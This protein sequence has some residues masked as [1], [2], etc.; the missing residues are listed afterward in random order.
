MLDTARRL[1]AV[2]KDL[3]KSIQPGPSIFLEFQPFVGISLPPRANP[4]EVKEIPRSL[5]QFLQRCYRIVQFVDTF[6]VILEPVRR[7][8]LVVSDQQPAVTSLKRKR[9]VKAMGFTGFFNNGPV[10]GLR[11]VGDRL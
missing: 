7:K 9:E 10:K 8:L 3:L 2:A 1:A 11:G 4:L 6:P 5:W